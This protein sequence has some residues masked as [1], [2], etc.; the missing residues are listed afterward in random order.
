[1]TV[2]P[3]QAILWT[4]AWAAVGWL[5][6]HHLAIGRD[7]RNRKHT[8]R[9]HVSSLRDNILAGKDSSLVEAHEKSVPRFREEC[10]KV[11]SDISCFKRSAFKETQ[12]AYCGLSRDE[13]ENRDHSKKPPPNRDAF[14]NYQPQI[15]WKPPAN[16]ARGRE[17]IRALLNDIIDC[18]K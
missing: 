4:S 18:A 7:S 11:E 1:M 9:A 10:A 15:G 17:R 3:L 13:I 6:G 12:T 14:G 2:T 16:Y 8:F 5:V